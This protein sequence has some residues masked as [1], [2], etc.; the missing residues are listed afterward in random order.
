MLFRSLYDK[1]GDEYT[2]VGKYIGSKIDI[3]IRHNVC[4]SEFM[5]RPN[6]ILTGNSRCTICHP[7]N[8]RKTQ[9]EFCKDVYN[10]VGDEYTVVGKYV[11]NK[12]PVEFVHNRCGTH[13]MTRPDLFLFAKSDNALCPSCM[14]LNQDK[15]YSFETVN[16]KINSLHDNIKLIKYSGCDSVRVE[17]TIHHRVYDSRL[18]T[19]LRGKGG[20]PECKR[21]SSII[22]HSKTHDDFTK[23]VA[24]ET[25]GE[26]TVVGT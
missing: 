8:Y 3:L 9:E 4:N 7:P 22:Y 23:Q 18:S 20:C 6:N 5:I 26:Y 11:R 24:E 16:D 15:I 2:V 19:L 14:I 25:N 12:I 17:C 21:E 1:Y 10:K 13:F